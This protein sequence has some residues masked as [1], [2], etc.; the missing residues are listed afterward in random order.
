MVQWQF[1][2]RLLFPFVDSL[3]CHIASPCTSKSLF[4]LCVICISDWPI[5]FCWQQ[6]EISHLISFFLL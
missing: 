1:Q 6:I 3:D 5:S 4:F 2:N